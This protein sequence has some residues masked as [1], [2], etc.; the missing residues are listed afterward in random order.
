[1]HFLCLLNENKP[2]FMAYNRLNDPTSEQS[3]IA[4]QLKRSEPMP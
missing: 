1:M 3:H 4:D 2:I